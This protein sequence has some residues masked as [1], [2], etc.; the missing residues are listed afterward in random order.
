MGQNKKFQSLGTQHGRCVIKA[1][2]FV[3]GGDIVVDNILRLVL[4]GP[5]QICFLITR[6][7]RLNQSQN[8]IWFARV[9][10]VVVYFRTVL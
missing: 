7:F 3:R 1:H 5:L 4:N 9:S 8:F 10:L 2:A 6:L